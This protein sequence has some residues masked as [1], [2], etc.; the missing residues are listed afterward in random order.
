MLSHIPQ[1]VFTELKKTENHFDFNF[2]HSHSECRLFWQTYHN[3]TV[4]ESYPFI[5]LFPWVWHKN[6]NLLLTQ[7]NMGKVVSLPWLDYITGDCVS[8][9]EKGILLLAFRKQT[10]MLQ[11]AYA[12]GLRQGVIG[13]L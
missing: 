12:E 8:R 1:A 6:C 10:G 9:P 2:F 3:V 7:K 11:I 5:I 13:S 4:S